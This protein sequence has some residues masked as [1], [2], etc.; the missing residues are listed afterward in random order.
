MYAKYPIT[1]GRTFKSYSNKL[2]NE[3]R[4][5]EKK[6]FDEKFRLSS[7]DAA[8]T[9]K[10]IDTVLGRKKKKKKN[11]ENKFCINNEVTT[12]ANVI[13]DEFNRFFC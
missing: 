1:Y 4:Q 6:Y 13:V 3:I 8:Q 12:E 2:T 11:V 10:T 7:N 5:A 9:W